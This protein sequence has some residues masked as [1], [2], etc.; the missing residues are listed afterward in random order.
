MT[1]DTPQDL[2]ILRRF[3]RWAIITALSTV[4]LIWI[5]GWVRSTGSGM[6]CPDWPKCFGVWIPPTTEAALPADY[7]EKY[8]EQRLKKNQR[9]AKT[10]AKLGFNDLAFLIQNDPSVLIHEPFNAYK[11]WTEYLNRVAGVLVGLF[12]FLTLIFSIPARK[13]DKRLFWLSL[14]AFLGVGFEGWLGSLVVSTNLMP[15]FITVHMVL[16]MAILVA[17]ISAAIIAY[18]RV[19]TA[20]ENNFTISGNL[21]GG[22]VVVCVLILIQIIIG[23]QVRENVDVV[24]AALG[25]NNRSEIIDNL[26]SVYATHRLFYYIVAAAVLFFAFILRGGIKKENALFGIR[27]VLFSTILMVAA[28]FGEI[29]LGISMHRFGLPPVLQPLHLL[30]ATV[31]FSAAYMTTSFLWFK[32][33]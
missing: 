33:D 17:L 26:G 20:D 5:G 2:K 29:L 27:G 25:E 11:T 18:I 30:F 31:L 1:N 23:T 10:L 32:K 22:G 24:K 28:L 16:A 6:G 21:I 14:F 19:Q 8:G 7:L 15:S 13:L 4:F 9:V 12:I 3:R